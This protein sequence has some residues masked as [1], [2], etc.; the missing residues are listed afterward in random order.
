MELIMTWATA[1]VR[2]TRRATLLSLGIAVACGGGGDIAAPPPAAPRLQIASVLVEDPATGTVYFSHDDHWHGFPTVTAG[3]PRRLLMHFVKQGRAPDDHD[4]PPRNEWFTLAPHADH[5]LPVVIEDPTRARWEGDRL[6][7]AL[8]AAQLHRALTARR[9][10]A[11][12]LRVQTL[13]Q[14]PVP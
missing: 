7:G 1:R 8:T 13:F 11:G 4:M 5:S 14:P 2:W 9:R 12:H 6:G 3:A 10:G